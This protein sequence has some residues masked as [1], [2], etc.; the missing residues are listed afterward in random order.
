MPRYVILE[1]DHPHLHWDF[2]LEDEG[3]LKTWRL[4]ACPTPEPCSIAAE[5]IGDHRLA[6]LDYEGPVGGGRGAVRRWDAGDY[7]LERVDPL[8]LHLRGVRWSGVVE[9]KGDILLF[10]PGAPATQP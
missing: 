4:S 10:H 1:H 3:I 2:M 9:E 6:Y 8:R 7:D 5:P